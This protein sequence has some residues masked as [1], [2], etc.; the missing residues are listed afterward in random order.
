MIFIDKLNYFTIASA[1]QD[2]TQYLSCLSD[3]VSRFV[4]E[5]AQICEPDNI[6]ICDGSEEENRKMIDILLTQGLFICFVCGIVNYIIDF[7]SH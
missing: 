6:H 1:M 2:Y 7:R 3:S 5:K 4:L